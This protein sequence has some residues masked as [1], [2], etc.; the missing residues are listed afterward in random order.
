MSI[1]TGEIAYISPLTQ[2]LFI[3]SSRLA[4]L[5]RYTV[6][7]TGPK[8]RLSRDLN[9]EVARFPEITAKMKDIL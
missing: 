9:I 8:H 6:G 5:R 2:K 7:Y 3:E 1:S 4:P